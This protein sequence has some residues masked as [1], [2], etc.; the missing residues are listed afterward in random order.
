MYCNKSLLTHKV[1]RLRSGESEMHAKEI[2]KRAFLKVVK[3]LIRYE[4][5]F[6]NYH[7]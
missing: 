1:Y 2:F 3:L 5:L 4:L 6:V 7:E